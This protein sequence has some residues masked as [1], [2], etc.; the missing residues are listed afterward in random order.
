MINKKVKRIYIYFSSIMCFI[1]GIDT[2]INPVWNSSKF[3]MKVDVTPI[4]FPLGI[5]F[6]IIGLILIYSIY[7]KKS[8]TQKE[9]TICPKC[10]ET[11]NYNE[12]KN[13]K[14][15]YCEDV[16]TID[17]DKYYKEHPEELE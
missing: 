11:F 4:S 5:A 13:G 12:L 8:K 16:D 10:K 14:C 1:M 2:I 7:R 6:I 15:K 17:T 3:Q 9:Y